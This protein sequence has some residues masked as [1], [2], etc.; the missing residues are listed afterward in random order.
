MDRISGKVVK[1]LGGL[2]DVRYIDGGKVKVVPCVAR[3]NLKRGD[4]KVYV[5]DKV[6]VTL[7]DDGGIIETIEKRKNLLIRPP[8]ANL[9]FLFIT[10]SAASPQPMLD[11]IDKMT[12]IAK[13]NG[14][15]VSVIVTKSD[16]SDSAEKYARIYRGVGYET[17]ICSS[18]DGSGV[19]E[20]RDHV[21][22][23]LT[24]GKTG[25]FAGASGVGKSTLINLLFPGLNLATGDIS[26][27]IQ[28]G[29]HT[30]RHVQIY[31]V[32]NTEN[33]GFLADTP[34]FSLIDFEHFDFFG[35]DDL[36]P[37]FPDLYAYNGK[38]RYADCT[39]TKEKECEI[40]RAVAEGKVA[41]SRWSS[42]LELYSILKDKKNYGK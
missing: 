24:D 32:G 29:K 15:D 16:K 27:K 8:L 22:R 39:H 4:D 20:V 31:D 23:K 12:A 37:A 19:A 18:L 13:H 36:L 40:A 38:C 35:L 14:I 42:Y 11:T 6:T 9:D 5:G 7:S 41:E 17:F 26:R 34:G 30:T 28:R 25:A 3:G 21:M 2:F 10:F 1:G 33:C